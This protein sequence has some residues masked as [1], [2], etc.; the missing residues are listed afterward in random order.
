[1]TYGYEWLKPPRLENGD[2]NASIATCDLQGIRHFLCPTTGGDPMKCLDCRGIKT[3]TTGQR[4]VVL[5][6]EATRE[7]ER[8]KW[9]EVWKEPKAMVEEKKTKEPAK[10][11]QPDPAIKSAKTIKEQELLR[12]A[13]ESGNAWAYL[14]EMGYSKGV[15]KE[16]VVNLVNRYP[17]IG[18]E[19]GGIQR[20]LKKPKIVHITHLRQEEARTEPEVPQ[21]PP[22][23]TEAREAE[24]FHIVTAEELNNLNGPPPPEYAHLYDVQPQ[25]PP[26]SEKA[27]ERKTS[28]AEQMR[29]K[30]EATILEAIA[31]GDPVQWLMDTRG[32]NRSVARQTLKRWQ[33][34]HPELFTDPAETD[35][36]IP[37][38]ET[39]P[40]PKGE[41]VPEKA[42]EAE[43]EETDEISLV[44]FLAKYGVPIFGENAPPAVIGPE[45]VVVPE[46]PKEPERV[47][48]EE[49]EG[50][51][52]R[53][54]N[55]E[56]AE[57]MRQEAQV[58]DE[59][60]NLQE[61]VWSIRE[62]RRKIEQKMS[63]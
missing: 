49:P 41:P 54:W 8:T 35:A 55:R 20:I 4:A 17:G 16:K 42:E 39:P 37:A 40:V 62:R 45:G 1:M 9:K 24:P 22:M 25:E 56:L 31:S 36:P 29:T 52:M 3:C 58:L 21:E 51:D 14:M 46:A 32:N 18:R 12:A 6:D 2:P 5:L 7:T 23:E 19:F 10:E 38:E 43:Q 33:T 15:A 60:A 48:L 11:K 57:L 50:V 61:R 27:K 30:T 59:I 63:H 28:P 34:N 13:C 53:N 26:A 47:V 44:D